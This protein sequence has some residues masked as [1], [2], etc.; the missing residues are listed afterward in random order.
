MGY[1]VTYAALKEAFQQT[2]TIK[3][4]VHAELAAH[5]MATSR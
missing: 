2:E 4:F 5:R 1:R 3:A